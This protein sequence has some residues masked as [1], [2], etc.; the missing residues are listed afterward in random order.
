MSFQERRALVSIISTILINIVY[1]N[2]MIPRYPTTGDNSPEVFQFWGVY[3]VGLIG[4]T[5]V[6]YII[7]YIMFVILNTIATREEE[8]SIVD[9]RDKLIDLK[10]SRNA[11]FVF[12]VGFLVAMIMLA[13]GLPPTLMFVVLIGAGVASSL[14]SD[15]S[16]FYFYRRGY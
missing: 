10:S 7:I 16:Q 3:L 8:P 1:A 11:L 14:T 5:I 2:V 15:V 13:V 12:Q 4:V 9:E 6:A